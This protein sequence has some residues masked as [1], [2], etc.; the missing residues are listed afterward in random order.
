MMF[1]MWKDESINTQKIHFVDKEMLINERKRASVVDNF[2]DSTNKPDNASH[3]VAVDN[4]A[5]ENANALHTIIYRLFCQSWSLLF[6]FLTYHY[7][8]PLSYYPDRCSY[9]KLRNT[10]TTLP[11]HIRLRCEV[12]SIWSSNRRTP[13]PLSSTPCSI[14]RA[15]ARPALRNVTEIF[16]YSQLYIL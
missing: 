6:F 14:C 2:K 3:N 13:V 9:P 5:P 7:H 10:S 11:H 15:N 1:S 16:L 8:F 4:N 12:W